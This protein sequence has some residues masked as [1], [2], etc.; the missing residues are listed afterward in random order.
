MPQAWWLD[1]VSLECRRLLRFRVA[2]RSGDE[3][4]AYPLS[5]MGPPYVEARE[6]PNGLIINGREGLEV[7]E[8]DEVA[9]RRDPG[10][11]NGHIAVEREQPG[12]PARLD[13]LA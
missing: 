10:P 7:S 8:P 5:A 1:W 11:P 4:F 3:R 13:T 2:D 6:A 9:P 12:R